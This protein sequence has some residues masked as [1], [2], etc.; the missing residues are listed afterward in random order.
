MFKTISLEVKSA[1]EGYDLLKSV[2]GTKAGFIENG[3]KNFSI[4]K[5]DLVEQK[6]LILPTNV[7]KQLV[8][9]LALGYNSNSKVG[10][11]TNDLT[12][13]CTARPEEFYNEDGTL[14]KDLFCKAFKTADRINGT[15]GEYKSIFAE[16]ENVFSFV[17]HY[18]NRY[19]VVAHYV[20]NEEINEFAKRI[21]KLDLNKITPEDIVRI[22]G[23]LWYLFRA[24]QESSIDVV[25]DKSKAFKKAFDSII[26]KI[27]V[28]TRMKFKDIL[29]NEFAIRAAKYSEDADETPRFAIDFGVFDDDCNKYGVKYVETTLS[30]FQDSI[31]NTL[32]DKID[33]IVDIYL[34]TNMSVYKKYTK[35]AHKYPELALTIANIL[36]LTR[37]YGNT[38]KEEKAQGKKLNTK[39]YAILRA[40]VFNDAD[41]L[42]IDRDDVVKVG[43]AA[44][45][46]DVYVDRKGNIVVKDFDLKRA[47]MNMDHV[48]RIFGNMMLVEDAEIFGAED[49]VYD[50]MIKTE[51]EPFHVFEDV[52]PDIYTMIDGDVYDEEDNLLFDTLENYTGDVEVTEDGKV[53]YYYDP[54]DEVSEL[55]A[56]DFILSNQMLD[57]EGKLDLDR[58]T[59]GLMLDEKL[60]RIEGKINMTIDAAQKEDG[61]DYGVAV[62]DNNSYFE[63][64]STVK[65]GEYNFN[66]YYGVGGPKIRIK[67]DEDG[68]EIVDPL[69]RN[70]MFLFLEYDE[71][72]MRDYIQKVTMFME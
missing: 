1:Q 44:A 65:P 28:R 36:K 23:D 43:I 27:N 68:E 49:M 15:V 38:T 7:K 17:L 60:D 52:E 3:I 31:R 35:Y 21:S 2:K 5:E 32:Q 25:K 20:S 11:V 40:V 63:V 67:I 72:E 4:T 50:H 33:E 51:I 13:I 62:I 64:D 30:D 19:K 39:D 54:V 26:G 55:P 24:W 9:L 8:K 16:D 42:E 59:R 47:A 48:E 22:Q 61:L 10:E 46:V 41:E 45:C 29:T 56:I 71:E 12:A 34:D 69:K 70:N 18:D 53:I 6:D 66:K 58:E 57:A 14:N 37:D